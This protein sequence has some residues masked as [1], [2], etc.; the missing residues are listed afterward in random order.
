[1]IVHDAFGQGIGGQEEVI[2]AADQSVRRQIFYS[3]SLE[4]YKERLFQMGDYYRRKVL[5]YSLLEKRNR[6]MQELL[7]EVPGALGKYRIGE[8][9]SGYY[10]RYSGKKDFT[11]NE[12]S[13]LKK[14]FDRYF[15]FVERMASFPLSSTSGETPVDE[16]DWLLCMRCDFLDALEDTRG[17]DF[18]VISARKAVY[19]VV[20]AGE[21]GT[22]TVDLL[23]PVLSYVKK[24]GYRI[25]G[26][27]YGILLAKTL[28]QGQFRR[29]I[30]VYVP[31][32]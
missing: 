25:C 21:E 15:S 17:E 18:P 11:V 16:Y 20:Y 10:L 6:I 30:G 23:K 1:M 13:K 5:Y 19:T 3:D 4:D 24:Q 28:D 29:Y 14:Y 8:Y 27:V 26:N 22:F 2:A 32:E 9:P 7:E 31:V 12:D